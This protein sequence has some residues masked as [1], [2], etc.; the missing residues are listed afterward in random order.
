MKLVNF[1]SLNYDYVYGVDHMV[2]PGETL[3]SDSMETFC[4]GKGLNQSI[5]L[6]R[7]GVSVYHAGMVGEEGDIL[8]EKCKE[9][10]IDCRF[11]AKVQGKSGHTIIQVDKNGQNS[12][13]LF[14][15]SNGKNTLEHVE[16]VLDYFQ[17]GDMILLQNE[18]NL[19]DK[20]IDKA[21]EKKMKIVLNPSP[22]NEKVKACDLSK[23]SVFLMN[24]IEGY[25]ITGEKEPENILN[26][27]ECI[28]PNSE[29]VLTLGKDGVTYS[30][31]GKRYFRESFKV[32]AVDTTAAGDTFTGYFLASII[33]EKSIEE[34][35]KIG[36]FAASI[37]VTRKGASSSIPAKD[38]VENRLM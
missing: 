1:G 29:V 8:I 25:Q 15:G 23:V 16:E 11:I 28:Y 33:E 35:L 10:Q 5:A 6:A 26:V 27:M 12:I 3:S 22:F 9:N 4:G 7:A 13:L 18:I 30:G 14:P 17:E 2:L 20:I 38:E 31:N 37:A 32:K 34:A 19:L 24:E 36:S 21:Y